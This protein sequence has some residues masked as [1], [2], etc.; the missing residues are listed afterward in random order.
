MSEPLDM[1]SSYDVVA[2]EYAERIYDELRHKPFD[3]DL[4]DR[5]ATRMKGRGLVCDIGCGPGQIGRYLHDRGVS[6]VGLDLSP[7]ML[8][9]ARRLNPE[10]EFRE[11]DM[12][13]LPF[14]DGELAAIV[15]FYAVIHIMRSEV[16][17]VLQEFG[18]V[19]VAGGPL[20]LAFHVGNDEGRNE[21]WW[22]H[23]VSVDWAFYEPAEMTTYLENAGFRVEESLE[24]EP[25]PEVEAQTQRCYI[26]AVKS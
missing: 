2:A 17:L 24:R 10:M 19:L 15:S 9:Q 18:R 6:V 25:Y 1:K 4:L 11:A 5:F 14:A 22:G 16:A 7:G 20:L 26:L 23:K 21:E 13:R 3:R 8:A 12:R